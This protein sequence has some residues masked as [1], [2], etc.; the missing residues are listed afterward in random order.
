MRRKHVLSLL[1]LCTGV[2]LLIAATTVGVASSATQKVSSS[3]ALRG[4][5]LRINQSAGAFDT[6]DPGLAYVTNDWE[7]LYSTGLNL[8]NFPNKAGAAG[9]QLFPE[10]AKAFP[11][12]SKG[13]RTVTF[14]L[15]S[16]LRFS[17]GS[18]VTAAAY[19]RAWERILSPKMYAQY[20]IFDQLNKMVVGAQ[21]FTDG[22]AAHISGISAKGLTLTFHLVKPNPTFVNI[23]GMQWF[24]AVKPSMKYTKSSGGILKYPSAGPYYIATNQPGRLTVL[25]RNKYYHGQRLA[26]PNQIVIN[27]FPNSNGEASLLQIE[28]NQVDFDMGGVPSADVKTVSA[29]YGGPNKGQFHV[30]TQA[31]IIWE[32]FNNAKAPTNNANVRKALNYAIGRTPI[33]TTLGPFAGSA[34]DQ[35][36]VPGLSGYKKLKAYGNFPDFAKAKAVG[37]SALNGAPALNIYYNAAS[38][39]RTTEAEFIQAQLNHIGLKANLEKSDPTDY[40]GP[41]ETKGTDYNIA[42]SGWCAD[43]FDPFDFINVNFDGRSIQPTGNVD[44]FYFNNSAFN[45]Q[46]DHAASLSG[47]ARAS[48]Y[49]AL[50]KTLMTK[51]APAF[52]LYVPN[53]R[54]L[55]SARVKNVIYSNY[56]GYPILNAMS[57]G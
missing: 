37:G 35:V 53:F 34:S 25:K 54:Y 5:T 49:A 16:G 8:V 21:K 27:S 24:N 32:A 42:H 45:K 14:H 22:K 31:C 33:I 26:N 50:D 41:I 20:G 30:G 3:K 55:T 38:A 13:G 28:K 7:V 44:Y 29:K 48:A 52:P 39:S 47:K 56:F 19:Q 15:R 12:I 23:L 4:G 6:L 11:T 46:M 40:Y 17:D 2:A 9:S 51:Y 57:V 36:L 1:M 43:Y 10:A 18:K